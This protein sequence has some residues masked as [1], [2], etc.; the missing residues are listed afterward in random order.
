MLMY[1]KNFISHFKEIGAIQITLPFLDTAAS[2]LTQ[3]SLCTLSCNHQNNLH[4]EVHYYQR[5]Q[6]LWKS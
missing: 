1:F 5:V 4:Y 2:V 3:N 6:K